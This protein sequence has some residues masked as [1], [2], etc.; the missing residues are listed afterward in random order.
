MMRSFARRRLLLPI[1]WPAAVLQA[2]WAQDARLLPAVSRGSAEVPF[3]IEWRLG[4][5]FPYYV[6]G[7]A[8]GA[9]DGEIVWAG[10]M[11]FPW[12]EPTE[13]VLLRISA[14]ENPAHAVHAYC[15][16]PELPVKVGYTGGVSVG[17]ALYVVGGRASGKRA[18]KLTKGPRRAARPPSGYSEFEW[19]W[20]ALPDTSERHVYPA[21]VAVGDRVV[22]H[23]SGSTT[24]GVAAGP[25]LAVE[26]LDTKFPERGWARL[27]ACPSAAAGKF[28]GSARGRLYLFGGYSPGTKQSAPSVEGQFSGYFNNA[29]TRT[30][31]VYDF[32]AAAW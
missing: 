7:G 8:C 31:Y 20:E 4:P 9:L 23:G 17:S 5:D 10:G 3:R 14:L 32:G 25:A 12:R 1:L 26:V 13:T 6:K 19:R 21:V 28:A 24:S 22:V 16:L 15:W 2:L 27:P 18:F 30:S 11:Q 29:R